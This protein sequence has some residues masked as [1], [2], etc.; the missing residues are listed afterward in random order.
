MSVSVRAGA[1]EWRRCRS[2]QSVG[3]LSDRHKAPSIRL[4]RRELAKQSYRTFVRWARSTPKWR[5]NM[6]EVLNVIC[7][8]CYGMLQPLDYIS[9]HKKEAV[10]VEARV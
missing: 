4:R 1:G 2:C 3:H 8:I 9:L 10:G 6:L 5:Q 7:I